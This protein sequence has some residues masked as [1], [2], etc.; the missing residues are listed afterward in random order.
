[1]IAFKLFESV[2]VG[3]VEVKV[4]K[5]RFVDQTSALPELIQ[6]RQAVSRIITRNNFDFSVLALNHQANNEICHIGPGAKTLRHNEATIGKR[7]NK[8][9][10]GH[11]R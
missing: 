2:F 6:M 1:M 10:F 11:S 9:L 5:P 3:C 4:G 8:R 7:N